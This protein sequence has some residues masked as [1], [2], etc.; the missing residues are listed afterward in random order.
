MDKH[1]AKLSA[2]VLLKTIGFSLESQYAVF[3]ALSI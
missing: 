2:Y 1:N 3:V